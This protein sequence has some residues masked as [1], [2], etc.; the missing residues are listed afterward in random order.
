[1][2]RRMIRKAI[3]WALHDPEEAARGRARLEAWQRSMK[4]PADQL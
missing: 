4:L 2:I 1:M 3:L